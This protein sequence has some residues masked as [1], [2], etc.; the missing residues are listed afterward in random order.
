MFK[1]APFLIWRYLSFLSFFFFFFDITVFF[2]I[3]EKWPKTN[4]NNN[5]TQRVK[6]KDT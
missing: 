6:S 3:I 4:T 2:K 5:E 1:T